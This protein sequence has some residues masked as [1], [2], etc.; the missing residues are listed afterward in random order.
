[1]GYFRIGSRNILQPLLE[2]ATAEQL[3]LG[4]PAK[5]TLLEIAELLVRWAPNLYS[6]CSSPSYSNEEKTAAKALLKKYDLEKLG[7]LSPRYK[8][9]TI[10]L[11]AAKLAKETER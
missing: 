7:N 9:A 8:K 3:S 6:S 10:E 1:L 5:K 4:A 11:I 2:Q